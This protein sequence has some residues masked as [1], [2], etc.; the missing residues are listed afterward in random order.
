[1]NESGLNDSGL[2]ELYFLAQLMAADEPHAA[3]LV[4]QAIVERAAGS[5]LPSGKLLMALYDRGEPNGSDL[6]QVRQSHAALLSVL[7]GLIA[8]SSPTRR[9]AIYQAFSGATLDPVEKSTFM[10]RVRR[11]LELNS[12]RSNTSEIS[13][14]DVSRALSR[15]LERSLAPTP[16]ALK[17][18]LLSKYAPESDSASDSS[19]RKSTQT[20]FGPSL[21]VK[22]AAAIVLI[23]VAS[24]I[25]TWIARP[26]TKAVVSQGRPDMLQTIDQFIPESN[27]IFQ[28]SD[29]AQIERVLLDRTGLK[30]QV[31][32]LDDGSIMG[33]SIEKLAP[34]LSLAVIH[35]ELDGMAIN[36][37]VLDYATIQDLTSDFDFDSAVLN[38][39]AQPRGL[40]IHQLE[41]GS[42]MTF[43]NRDDVYITHTNGNPQELRN[44]FSF[45]E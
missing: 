20:P 4:E 1:M 11:A 22:V 33:L 25:A 24:A 30:I 35:Y 36:V 16:P 19:V 43:R 2:D 7:P 42:R 26:T 40:D 13:E 38:Q 44:L 41:E 32:H 39:I 6:M 18:A 8:T 3:R 10:H 31:P 15:F 5:V 23:L 37:Y 45:D 17:S 34:A 9:V 14:Q 28:G 12:E 29:I 21:A 27:L